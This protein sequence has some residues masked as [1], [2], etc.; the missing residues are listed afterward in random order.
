M[1]TKDKMLLSYELESRLNAKLE[2]R[3]FNKPTPA[4]VTPIVE[5]PKVKQKTEIEL[6]SLLAMQADESYQ[7]KQGAKIVFTGKLSA[8][9]KQVKKESKQ[10]K[11]ESKTPV[12]PV[13]QERVVVNEY[14][15]KFHFYV[16]E[17]TPMTKEKFFCGDTALP[18]LNQVTALPTNK[19]NMR[20][21]A[22]SRKSLII[23]TVFMKSESGTL[24]KPQASE[25]FPMRFKR[26]YQTTL[27]PAHGFNMALDVLGGQ[28][29]LL[30]LHN[31]G[32][33]EN[34]KLS[35]LANI[36]M[37]QF[38]VPKRMSKTNKEKR[39]HG[40]FLR[41]YFLKKVSGKKTKAAQLRA[42]NPDKTPVV[43]TE[44]RSRGSVIISVMHNGE[45]V[46]FT[47]KRKIV[48]HVSYWKH[49]AALSIKGLTESEFRQIS[50][51]VLSSGNSV[52]KK[53]GKWSLTFNCQ[54]NS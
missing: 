51:D 42:L 11:Q 50:K 13:L 43:K 25:H 40:E 16:N 45:S 48:N 22:E 20:T 15:K 53:Y 18:S 8:W 14:G 38:E 3:G 31:S 7:N 32:K 41:E 28:A 2:S 5:K 47:V 35:N 44:K 24:G 49:I 33:I 26:I 54:K 10:A 23:H 39:N 4:I 1:K 30:A 29:A 52:T 37:A 19:A 46:S 36:L 6:D 17:E 21:I 12:F 27:N 34:L 9:I